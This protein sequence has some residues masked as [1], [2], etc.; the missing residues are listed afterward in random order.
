MNALWKS[1]QLA[2]CGI[3]AALL[4][5]CTLDA[6]AAGATGSFDRTL[7]V[8]G[9]VELSVQTGSGSI[10][11]QPGDDRSVHVIGRIRARGNMWSGVSA[12]EQIRRLEAN[13]PIE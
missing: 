12:E 3:V 9:A 11:I 1:V 13:P 5:A 2:A 8:S 7:Q 10:Q 6:Q 4:A